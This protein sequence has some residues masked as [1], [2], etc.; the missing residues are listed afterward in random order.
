MSRKRGKRN[1]RKNSA[2]FM[3][4]TPLAL[5][6]FAAAVISLSYLWLE[7]RSVELDRRI[8][9]LEKTLQ[10]TRSRRQSWQAR[11]ARDTSPSHLDALLQRHGL[12]MSFAGRERT[13]TLNSSDLPGVQTGSDTDWRMAMNE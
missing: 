1:K 13:V 2:G 3:F 6:L 11:W 10:Q 4:P 5:L 7:A 9:S 8:G 12:S